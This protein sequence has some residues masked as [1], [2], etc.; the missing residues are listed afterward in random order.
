MQQ[1]IEAPRIRY[2]FYFDGEEPLVFNVTHRDDASS[3]AGGEGDVPSWALLD[4]CRCSHCSLPPE[5]EKA[6]PA[7]MSI[8]PVIETFGERVSF[9]EVTVCVEMDGKETSSRT[10]LQ[11]AIRSLIGLMM[12]LSTCPAMTMLRPMAYFH[13]PLGNPQDASF[14]V[15]G[16]YLIGQYIRKQQGLSADWDM[17][18]LAGI[19]ERIHVANEKIS[20]RLQSAAAEDATVN[21]LVILDVFVH[22]VDRDLDTDLERWKNLFS[23]YL[24]DVPPS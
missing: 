13:L 8:L 21:S 16:M 12:T 1:G 14:R 24:E 2:T 9:E 15:I 17:K 5:E 7:A 6:C 18:G 11:E 4:Y 22:S 10:S 3:P 20:E 23:V 19:F